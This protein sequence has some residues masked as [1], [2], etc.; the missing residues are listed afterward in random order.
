MATA[1]QLA[2][3]K[4]RYTESCVVAATTGSVGEETIL[5]ETGR[6]GTLIFKSDQEIIYP[7]TRREKERRQQGCF[8]HNSK[9]WR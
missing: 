5:P 4:K 1:G 8:E 2:C 3:S 7:R 9:A 6:A